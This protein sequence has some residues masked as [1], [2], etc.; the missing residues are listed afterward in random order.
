M[1]KDAPPGLLGAAHPSYNNSVLDA[2]GGFEIDSSE[3][4]HSEIT[5]EKTK[6][7][8]TEKIIFKLP[9]YNGTTSLFNDSEENTN[10]NKFSGPSVQ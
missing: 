10:K 7:N 2:E 6:Q 1:I 9:K 3:K 8:Q 5:G 4:F